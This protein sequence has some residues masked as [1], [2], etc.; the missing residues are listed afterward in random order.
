MA[1]FM[2]AAPTLSMSEDTL[3][4]AG[5]D[6]TL[7]FRRKDHARSLSG[8]PWTIGRLIVGAGYAWHSISP[9]PTVSFFG[10]GSLSVFDGCNTSSGQH[11]VRGDQLIL[12]NLQPITDA[13]CT[14]DKVLEISEQVRAVFADGAVQYTIT[15]D[16]LRIERGSGGLTALAR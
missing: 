10:S 8:Q 15:V 4:L 9:P 12:S 5:D 6:A 1:Q 2:D 3:I 11:A 13:V 14:E 16:R 7:T